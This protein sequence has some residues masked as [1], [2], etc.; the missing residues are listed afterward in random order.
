MGFLDVFN[1]DRMLEWPECG[2]VDLL[3]DVESRSLSGVGLGESFEMLRLIGRPG[4]DAPLRGGIFKYYRLGFTAAV[5][6]GKIDHF[7]FIMIDEDGEGFEPGA[8][9]VRLADGTDVEITQKTAPEDVKKF[10]GEPADS[11]AYDD[12]YELTYE[13]KNLCLV[14]E[15]T[16]DGKLLGFDAYI[17]RPA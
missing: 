15:F 8:V 11:A 6:R 5:T 4:N 16:Q 3:L 17:D 9:G 2:D 1:K 10:F 14:F 7:I 12:F 13:L